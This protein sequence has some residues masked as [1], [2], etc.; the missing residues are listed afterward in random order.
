M[1]I[2]KKTYL[3]DDFLPNLYLSFLPDQEKEK[4]L[5]TWCK[6]YDIQLRKT[7]TGHYKVLNGC[8]E[9]IMFYP[10]KNKVMFQVD[11]KSHVITSSIP[12]IVAMIHGTLPFKKDSRY[13]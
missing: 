1:E 2:T 13:V 11:G 4:H 10:H 6:K 9:N 7:A 3:Q 12:N 5:L 8:I